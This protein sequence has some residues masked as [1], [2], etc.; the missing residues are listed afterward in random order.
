M[1][2]FQTIKNNVYLRNGVLALCFIVIFVFFVHLILNLSTRHGQ[3]FDVPDLGGLTMDEARTAARE[4]NLTLEVNDSLY[5]P[6]RTGGV[7]LEQH[8]SPGSKVKSGRRIFLT[9]NSYNPKMAPIPYVTGFSL[10]QAKNN[11]EVA[12]FEIEQLIYRDDIAANNVLEELF[13]GRVVQPRSNLQAPTGSGITLIVGRGDASAVKVPKVVGFPLKDA[14][15]R[16][17]EQGLNVGRIARDE[18]ITE[19]N[20][21]EA[22]VSRQSP[23]VGTLQTL[24]TAVEL[25]L[26][27]DPEAITAGSAAADRAARQAVAEAENQDASAETE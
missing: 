18:G 3:A 2:L 11:I 16:L 7:I 19:L 15:S 14:K 5:L 27:L 21:H 22:R 13:N 9:I 20:L 17:W 12:G 4:A 26:S 25:H 8:P 1:G 6:G 24:G 23:G 10:R